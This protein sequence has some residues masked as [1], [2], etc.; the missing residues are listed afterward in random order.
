MTATNTIAVQTT[1]SEIRQILADWTSALC[2]KNIDR[3]M[4]F[5]APDVMLFDI[6]PP[7]QIKGAG[8]VRR[9]WEDCFPCF[10]DSFQIEDRD[11]TVHVSNDLAIVHRI[12]HFTGE[13]KDHPA[14]QTWMRVTAVCKKHQGKWQIVH[15]HVSVPFNPETSQAVFTL[16]P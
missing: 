7:Y 1:E 13:D 3:L 5:Y 2:A 12:F 6:K 16:E 11:L 9:V 14:M 10:P 4:A 8:A 15:E